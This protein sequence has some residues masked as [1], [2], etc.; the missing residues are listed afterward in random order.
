MGSAL[1]A[2]AVA[3]RRLTP[4]AA[5]SAAHVDEDF[6]IAAWGEDAEAA[7]RRALRWRDMDAAALVFAATIG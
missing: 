6:Q 7:E 2:L 3:A 5:W 4:E 1:L